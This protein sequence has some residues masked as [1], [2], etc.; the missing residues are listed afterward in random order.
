VL[1]RIPLGDPKCAFGKLGCDA[2][3]GTRPFLCHSVR[4]GKA[5]EAL[6][7]AAISAVADR[8]PCLGARRELDDVFDSA[9]IAGPGVLNPRHRSSYLII[10]RI[11]AMI[12]LFLA[13]RKAETNTYEYWPA[14]VINPSADWC[15]RFPGY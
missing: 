3:G 7:N 2:E 5:E 1:R 14:K 15:C 4:R 13:G 9:A 10:Q 8:G 12:C 11:G 6:T